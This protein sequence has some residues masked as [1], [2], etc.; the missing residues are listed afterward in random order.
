ME[1]QIGVFTFNEKKKTARITVYVTNKLFKVNLSEESFQGSPEFLKRFLLLLER[2]EE[3][4]EDAYEELHEWILEPFR[5][6]F[7]SYSQSERPRKYTFDDWLFPEALCY[8]VKVAGCA[9]D[10]VL[11]NRESRARNFSVG[12]NLTRCEN[13]KDIDYSMFPVYSTKD[14]TISTYGNS[15]PAMPSRAFI[16]GQANYLKVVWAGDVKR[17]TREL[18]K[19]AMIHA[20]AFDA[21]VHTSRLN[22]LLRDDN[23]SV[24]GLLLD[25]IDCGDRPPLD[26]IDVMSHPYSEVKGKW[27]DQIKQTMHRLHSHGIIWGDAAATNIL[28]DTKDEAYL[29]DFG[30]GHTPGW[31][32]EENA[33]SMKG[34]LQGL[35]SIRSFLFG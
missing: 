1:H 31:V 11:L 2:L 6:T 5:P 34:D 12:A 13:G 35:E 24:V 19:Y 18:S 27:F 20:A 23:G 14:V 9:L 33:N 22:G 16:K 7:E 30:G 21:T 28:I 10:P 32:D 29:I 4:Y 8:T 25:Y 15:L 3:N 17:T 26:C